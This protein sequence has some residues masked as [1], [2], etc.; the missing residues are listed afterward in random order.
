MLEI[1][2]TLSHFRLVEKIGQGG[3]GEVYL[4][5]DTTLDRKVALK[6][7]PEAFTSDPERMARFER[8]AK[9]LASLNHPNIAGIYGLEQADGN[10]FLVLEYVAGETLQA[11]LSKGA[12]PLEEALELCRQI[13]EGL[14]AAHEKGVIHR[15]LKPANVMITAEEKVKILD[16]GLAKALSDDTQS[17]DSSQSPTLTE[18]MTQPGVILGTAAY[19]SP[20][21]AKGKAV[22]KRADIWAFGCILYECLSGKRVFEGETVTETLAAVIKE[23]P[24]LEKIPAKTRFLLRRCLEKDPKK[25]LRDIGDTMALLESLPEDPS[26][27]EPSRHSRLAWIWAAIASLLAI[28]LGIASIFNFRGQE[29]EEIMFLKIDVPASRVIQPTVSPDGHHI[30]FGAIKDGENML[31][32]RSFAKQ[33]NYPLQGTDDAMHPFWSPD[34]QSIGFGAEGKLKTIDIT[35]GYP[36]TLCDLPDGLLFRGGTWSQDD[37]LLFTGG[38]GSSLYQISANDG[39]PVAVTQLDQSRKENTHRFPF[40]LPDGEH[41]LFT[42]RSELPENHGIYIGSINSGERIQVINVLSKAVFAAPDYLLFAKDGKL[43]AQRFDPDRLEAT[44]EQMEI[45]LQLG[46]TV[47]GYSPFSVSETGRLI[48]SSLTT[49][50]AL[51]LVWMDRSGREISEIGLI[52]VEPSLSPYGNQIAVQ[53]FQPDTDST[54]IWLIDSDRGPPEPLTRHPGWD[55]HPI[56]SPD[57]TQIIF[58]SN[59]EGVAQ[60]FQASVD[61]SGSETQ[62]FVSTTAVRC[63]DWS[64]QHIV[65]RNDDPD[66][67]IDLWAL[68]LFGNREPFPIANSGFSEAQGRVS[69]DG[70]W[71]VYSSDATGQPEI[72]IQEFPSQEKRQRVTENGGSDPR[73]RRDGKELFYVSAD[74]KLM[75]IPVKLGDEPDFGTPEELF[76]AKI[77]NISQEGTVYDVSKDGKRFILPK[78]TDPPSELNVVLNWTQLLKK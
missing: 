74:G 49:L 23:P 66:T 68:P 36:K 73:W 71:I 45:N 8:E 14:E 27:S 51:P 3:M 47:L 77:F 35:G 48:Y 18:A 60:L 29:S 22:D 21:Q 15:D 19:M 24:D 38:G 40:F 32:L 17:I 12:L 70:N 52:G 7:L 4:A 61:G 53:R 50:F 30:V 20:E 56:W 11:R 58:S 63:T 46:N 65:Y 25:R 55:Q 26:V 2:Q 75:A 43:I 42:V 44:G 67:N 6:F 31:W 1:G 28:A 41:F 64:D 9:L 72:Y 34:S 54:D 76:D 10:R 57:G 5:D 33:Q 69:P 78:P 62:L 13:A 37:V 16:F 39:T 59:R